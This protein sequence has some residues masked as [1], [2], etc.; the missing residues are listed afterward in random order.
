MTFNIIKLLFF[1]IP[2][3]LGIEREQRKNDYS[4]QQDHGFQSTGVFGEIFE[5]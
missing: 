5:G 4:L 2:D 3:V 1:D